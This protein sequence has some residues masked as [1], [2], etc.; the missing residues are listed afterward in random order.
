MEVRA[1]TPDTVVVISS[2]SEEDEQDNVRE[3]VHRFFLNSLGRP[4]FPG[5]A[6]D[7]SVYVRAHPGVIE[8]ANAR[9][10]DEIIMRRRAQAR[11][12]YLEDRLRDVERERDEVYRETRRIRRDL[13]DLR[14]SCDHLRSMLG[15]DRP[16]Y[17]RDRRRIEVLEQQ[18]RAAEGQLAMRDTQIKCLQKEVAKRALIDPRIE[19]LGDELLRK[20]NLLMRWRQFAVTY[21]FRRVY[22]S[23]SAGGGTGS[24]LI[25]PES[26]RVR[27]VSADSGRGSAE[28]EAGPSSGR[29]S[30]SDL[31]P[32]AVRSLI[33]AQQDDSDD[34]I[35]VIAEVPARPRIIAAGERRRGG[36]RRS[37]GN[38][39]SGTTDDDADEEKEIKTE[40]AEESPSK[41]Q[42]KD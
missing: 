25:P 26:E 35:T 16:D 23:A 3:T 15:V 7:M 36:R 32:F 1:E 5:E 34:D 39:A 18:L 42:K 22:R 10:E 8:E 37:G 9:A 2:S 30:T 24:S 4:P 40:N 13:D 29:S 38:A 14:V 21:P 12:R 27:P 41:K 31:A 19:E 17:Q 11:V 33:A 20:N 28:L 6:L